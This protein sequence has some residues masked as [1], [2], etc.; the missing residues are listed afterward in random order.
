MEERGAL[1]VNEFLQVEGQEDIF[2][3][4]DCNNVKENKVVLNAQQQADYV[5]KN[6]PLIVDN[7]HTK[8]KPYRPGKCTSWDFIIYLLY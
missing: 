1:K 7:L 3:I 5:Y 8:V 6:L 2:A 4:G